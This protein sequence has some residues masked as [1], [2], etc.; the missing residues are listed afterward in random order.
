MSGQVQNQTG[1]QTQSQ[2]ISLEKVIEKLATLEKIEE[3]RDVVWQL[4]YLA[5]ELKYFA[6]KDTTMFVVKNAFR[7]TDVTIIGKYTGCEYFNVSIDPKSVTLQEL[8]EKFFN[9]NIYTS[10]LRCFADVIDNMANIINSVLPS[11]KDP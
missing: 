4:K 5:M 6:D 7:L 10:V 11:E 1:T 9:A 3:L 8:F 2:E